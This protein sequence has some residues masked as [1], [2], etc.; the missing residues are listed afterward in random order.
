MAKYRFLCPCGE[1]VTRYVKSTIETISCDL[2]NSDMQRQLPNSDSGNTQVR[3][4]VDPYTNRKW[5]KDNDAIIKQR[6]DD[7]YWE[8]EVPRLINTHSVQTSL[9]K[10]W[11]I[12]NAKGEL[13]INKPPSQR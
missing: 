7:H 8:V 2:C 12:Y 10:G 5:D 3:E 6:R 9:E 1:E 11:L 4:L 13:V